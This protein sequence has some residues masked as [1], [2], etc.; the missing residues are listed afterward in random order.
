MGSDVKSLADI[1]SAQNFV[2]DAE[3]AFDGPVDSAVEAE[4]VGRFTGK[5]DGVVDRLAEK[6]RSLEPADFWVAV[7][8]ERMRIG[9]PVMTKV[10]DE[11]RT[12]SRKRDAKGS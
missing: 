3:A 4:L 9:G 12:N 7:G 1:V 10:A 11:E 6:F 2:G 5:V 8:A